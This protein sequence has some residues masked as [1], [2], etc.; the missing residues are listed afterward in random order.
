M[1]RVVLDI[2]KKANNYVKNHCVEQINGS[3]VSIQ[4]ICMSTKNTNC[5]CDYNYG[6]FC[7]NIL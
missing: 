5:N 4:K 1:L 6:G 2:W 7:A 3:V